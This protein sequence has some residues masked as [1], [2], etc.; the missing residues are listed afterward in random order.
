MSWNTVGF[1]Q[2]SE[3]LRPHKIYSICLVVKAFQF[4]IHL[5]EIE[6]YDMLAHHSPKTLLSWS[7]WARLIAFRQRVA[8]IDRVRFHTLHT[9]P[10]L[11]R[12]DWTDLQRIFVIKIV[13]IVS[14]SAAQCVDSLPCPL[15]LSWPLDNG[16]AERKIGH[17]LSV[18][19]NNILSRI[20]SQIPCGLSSL[21][22]DHCFS[23][24][25]PINDHCSSPNLLAYKIRV[26]RL[27]DIPF[28]CLLLRKKCHS[29]ST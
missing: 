19:S 27:P 14:K 8:P 29:T 2:H 13:S 11:L 26:E 5:V 25:G 1:Q 24:P 18:N 21:I 22:E 16:V 6:N 28:H 20:L 10:R 15:L 7:N 4:V 9:S 17:P 12:K 23:E 3:I